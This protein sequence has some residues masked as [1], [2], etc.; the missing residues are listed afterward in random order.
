MTE[1]VAEYFTHVK[2]FHKAN[3][4]YNSDT[5]ERVKGFWINVYFATCKLSSIKYHR[6][7]PPWEQLTHNTT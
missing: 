4:M 3:S 7:K 1:D 6:K 2:L 5:H